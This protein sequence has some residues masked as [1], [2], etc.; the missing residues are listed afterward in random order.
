M[1]RLTLNTGLILRSLPR[2]GRVAAR[3]STGLSGDITQPVLGMSRQPLAG[4]G[5]EPITVSFLAGPPGGPGSTTV[6][7][8]PRGTPLLTLLTALTPLTISGADLSLLPPC[9]RIPRGSLRTRSTL[10]LQPPSIA[11]LFHTLWQKK[12]I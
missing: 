6:S 7:S 11:A 9:Q 12:N 10:V 4:G 8:D 2:E 5:G 1:R 3:L